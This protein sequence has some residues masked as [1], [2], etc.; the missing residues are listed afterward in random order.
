M[1][2]DLEDSA[3]PTLH[4]GL[5]K[6]RNAGRMSQ[7]GELALRTTLLSAYVG[8]RATG[9]LLGVLQTLTR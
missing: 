3:S 2:T 1:K 8:L 7:L 5:K 4:Q 9:Q 6:H